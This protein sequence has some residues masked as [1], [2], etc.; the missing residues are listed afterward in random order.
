VKV[1]EI[2]I[3]KVEFLNQ[4]AFVGDFKSNPTL[5]CLH[6][7]GIIGSNLIR[8]CNWKINFSKQEI[9]MINFVSEKELEGFISKDFKSYK[10][11][12]IN[13]GLS[14]NYFSLGGVLVDYG[15]NASVSIPRAMAQGAG[16]GDYPKVEL[17]GEQGMS[18]SG[19]VGKLVPFKREYFYTDFI[20]QKR[21]RIQDFEIRL[22]DDSKG[23][24]MG[25]KF[26]KRFEVI[27]DWSRKK[28]HL[29]ENKK[30]LV[31]HSTFGFRL[32]QS[33]EQI[34]ILSVVEGSDAYR[35]G[36]QPGVK[37][38]AIDEM[39]F[40]KNHTICDFIDCKVSERERINLRYV[41]ENGIEQE[42]SLKRERLW[43]D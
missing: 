17:F 37:V 18:Q 7:D 3:G 15:S 27:I 14:F 10:Q 31:D 5:A 39:D 29:K 2:R 30:V 6:I 21:D 9:C 8:H 42:V 19:I 13:T 34:S 33:D 11:Y 25:T 35:A 4:T 1:P 32:G 36:L 16:L 20:K 40:T 43:K 26:L 23:S 12:N 24:A 38:L 22:V 41:D 28:I